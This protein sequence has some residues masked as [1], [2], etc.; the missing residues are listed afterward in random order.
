MKKMLLALLLLGPITLF[1]APAS[2]NAP[3]PYRS[4]PIQGK[5]GQIHT[6]PPSIQIQAPSWVL[7]AYPSGQVL[8]G[9]DIHQRRAPASLAKLMTS[10]VLSNAVSHGTIHLQE[11]I[12][13]STKAWKTGGSKMFIRE[14]EKISV[15]DLMKGMI[16]SSGNDATIALAEHVAGSEQGF[17]DMMNQTAKALDLHDSH[18]QNPNGLPAPN[19]YSSAYDLA[20]LSRSL[21]NHFPEEYAWYKLK[22]FR[23]NKIT[24]KNPLTLYTVR[25]K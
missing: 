24:Q 13:I 1:A 2:S 10:Y 6:A 15:E 17:V 5:I 16:V 22:S 19:Q 3:M 8:A 12:L 20:L 4:L 9:K 25:Q 23:W 14:G 7:M 11:P 18:F 21:I